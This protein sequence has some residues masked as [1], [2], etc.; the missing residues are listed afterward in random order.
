MQAALQNTNFNDTS[1]LAL[2]A[3]GLGGVSWGWGSVVGAR[4]G[5]VASVPLCHGWEPG[6]GCGVAGMMRVR[7]EEWQCCAHCAIVACNSV[8]RVCGLLHPQQKA[9][10]CS[11]GA[12]VPSASAVARCRLQVLGLLSPI[13]SAFGI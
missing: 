9:K 4:V 11:R 8:F 3:G 6:G 13:N 12:R 1:G 10:Q 5:R 2:A 7:A